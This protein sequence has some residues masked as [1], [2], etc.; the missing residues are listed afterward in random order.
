MVNNL[1]PIEQTSKVNSAWRKLLEGEIAVTTSLLAF[2]VALEIFNHG[3]ATSVLDEAVYQKQFRLTQ[4]DK[5]DLS[6]T[7][8]IFERLLQTK[9]TNAKGFF[10]KMNLESVSY[11]AL[12]RAQNNVTSI[13]ITEKL[14]L[15]HNNRIELISLLKQ[16]KRY[17]NIHSHVKTEIS[18]LGLF[19]VLAG[20]VQRFS[21]LY[22]GKNETLRARLEENAQI[23]ESLVADVFVRSNNEASSKA[24]NYQVILAE[25]LRG[26]NETI[27]ELKLSVKSQSTSEPIVTIKDETSS[28]LSQ[29]SVEIVS[30]HSVE[31]EQSN[32][33]KGGFPDNELEAPGDIVAYPKTVY[34]TPGQAKKTLQVIQKKIATRTLEDGAKVTLN[35]NIL[36]LAIINEI[37]AKEVRSLQDYKAAQDIL[38]RYKAHKETMDVQL[39]FWWPE[40]QTVLNNIMWAE[41]IG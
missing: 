37:I 32:I 38:W 10:R 16:V 41:D 33:Q 30:G 12:E 40:I 27:E 8:A 15:A 29:G 24:E 34:Y 5:L 13:V 25:E 18:D 20:S 17:R 23:A 35:S 28:H 31:N 21:E 3:V 4:S 39:D 9:V 26:L 2:E 14:R 1:V 22:V 11:E 19:C 7:I 6:V 36:Q